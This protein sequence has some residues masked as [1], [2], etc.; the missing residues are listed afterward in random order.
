LWCDRTARWQAAKDAAKAVID[1]ASA[2]GYGLYMPNP[3]S[4][5]EATKNYSDIFLKQETSEDIY[6][7]YFTTKVDQNW[8]GYNPAFTTIPM[9]IMDGEAIRPHN[10]LLTSLK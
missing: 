9:A 3:A 2:A 8:D 5:D 7:K 10:N 4:A 1:M 6:F